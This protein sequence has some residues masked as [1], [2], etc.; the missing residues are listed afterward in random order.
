MSLSYETNNALL[1]KWVDEGRGVYHSVERVQTVFQKFGL[2][3][4]HAELERQRNVLAVADLTTL[5]AHSALMKEHTYKGK[6]PF[7][8]VVPKVCRGK[9]FSLS[10]FY[11]Y[12]WKRISIHENMSGQV[13]IG[14]CIAQNTKEKVWG[15]K[16]TLYSSDCISGTVGKGYA[17]QESYI[18]EC[19]QGDVVAHTDLYLAMIIHYLCTGEL[20]FSENAGRVHERDVDGYPTYI[21]FDGSEIKYSS[22]EKDADPTIGMAAA[23][24]F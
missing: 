21:H 6:N 9:D 20:L 22:Y 23:I 13:Y 10:N 1:Q 7:I 19:L 16:L 2:K 18:Q 17:A 4:S 12:F 24:P 5:S 14:P 8:L 3:F 11:E 15:D